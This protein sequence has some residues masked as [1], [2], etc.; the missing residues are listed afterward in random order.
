MQELTGTARTLLTAVTHK[1][2]ERC[3]INVLVH[4]AAHDG[5]MVLYVEILQCFTH[6]EDGQRGVE[7][8]LQGLGY[9]F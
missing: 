3:P 4:L 6:A 8:P 5:E 9:V 1:R 2:T 7:N